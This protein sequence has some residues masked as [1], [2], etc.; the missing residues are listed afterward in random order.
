MTIIITSGK[1]GKVT[2]EVTPQKTYCVTIESRKGVSISRN[3]LNS[4]EECIEYAD[5]V[6][7]NFEK[8]D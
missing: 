2:I 1:D 3:G 8:Q 7:K 5:Y 6:R 4:I